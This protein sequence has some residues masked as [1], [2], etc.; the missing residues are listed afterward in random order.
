MRKIDGT[1]VVQNASQ[2]A[3]F[4]SCA[5]KVVDDVLCGYNGTI[6]AY[7]QSGSGKTYTMS[8]DPKVNTV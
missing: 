3:C 4:N 5:L 8:G 1:T 7:G 6:L 2:E